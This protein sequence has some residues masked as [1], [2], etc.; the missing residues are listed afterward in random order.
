MKYIFFLLL[1]CFSL[2]YC[3][4]SK[5]NYSKD[6]AA[7][8]KSTAGEI[9]NKS[10]NIIDE[11]P[12]FN[13][14]TV[15]D[16]V[17]EI[18]IDNPT[19]YNIYFSTD[20]RNKINKNSSNNQVSFYI[21][22]GPL[23]NDFYII[24]EIFLS[25]NVPLYVR[26]LRG[27]SFEKNDSRYT[28]PEPRI[29]GYE[30]TYITIHNKV[31]NA[32]S[33]VIGGTYQRFL[34]QNGTPVTDTRLLE[35][36][37]VVFS[38]NTIAV[39]RYDQDTNRDRYYIRD[40]RKEIPMILPKSIERNYRYAY[41]YK[42]NGIELIDAR[43][44]H[45]I[46][47]SPRVIPIAQAIGTLKLVTQNNEISLFV[48]EDRELVRYIY[49]SK[50]NVKN[51][52]KNGNSFN[53]ECVINAGGSFFIA[54]FEYKNGIPLPVA[55]IHNANGTTRSAIESSKEYTSASL[56][57]VAQ[58]PNSNFWLLAGEGE[59]N[60][61]VGNFPYVRLV[62]ETGNKLN[63]EWEKGRVDFKNKDFGRIVSVIYDNFRSCWIISGEILDSLK[64]IIGS[65][66]AEIDNNGN[67]KFINESYIDMH[68]YKIL[69]DSH[70]MY[71]LIGEEYKG[72]E[73]YAVILKYDIKSNQYYKISTQSTSHSYYHD[74]LIDN[75][76]MQLVLVGVI[77]AKD[78]TGKDGIPFIESV[79]PDKNILIWRELL[80]INVLKDINPEITST[81]LVTGIAKAPDYGYVLTFSDINNDG[82][83]DNPY[84]I[85]RV[86]SQGKI[87]KE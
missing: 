17:I 80:S 60:R 24:Y 54:G 30:G 35:D 75:N 86:N 73:T 5:D 58:Q 31:N 21:G 70:G 28:I 71:Y 23:T 53:I 79:D 68:F 9:N 14:I 78:R 25:D 16:G 4:S 27:V 61:E 10:S 63:T 11:V 49:D 22:D 41:E 15:S 6:I 50:G 38:S 33:L 57:T 34:K 72:N 36:N 82:K 1:S 8:D 74:A 77:Q 46:A 29:E 67:I 3:I 2:T 42:T 62:R 44:L 76:N 87:L 84:L 39:F 47:E 65:F 64:E 56:F 7:T 52:I 18:I 83:C 45:L 66:L 48:P 37:K 59:K 55:R 85:A 40:S 12:F 43:P 13:S 81:A 20:L 32:I 26:G 69:I 19:G 51:I